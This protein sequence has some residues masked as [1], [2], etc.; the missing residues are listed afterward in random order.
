MLS[1]ILYSL[2]AAFF[3]FVG[4]VVICCCIIAGRSDDAIEASQG[5]G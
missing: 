3:V 1:I 2:G 4:A 5:R